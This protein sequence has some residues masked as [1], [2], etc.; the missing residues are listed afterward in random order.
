MGK[1][2]HVVPNPNGGW[3]VIGAGNSKTTKNTTTKKEAIE[4]AK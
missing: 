4:V 2:Q 1:N 3:S